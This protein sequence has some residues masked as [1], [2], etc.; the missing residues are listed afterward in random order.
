MTESS[1]VNK[2]LEEYVTLVKSASPLV[3]C[4][5]DDNTQYQNHAQAWEKEAE[6]LLNTYKK[7]SGDKND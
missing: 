7:L 5:N 4:F 3:W 6:R 1:A 2:L